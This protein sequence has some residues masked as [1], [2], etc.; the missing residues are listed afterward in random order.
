MAR[1]PSGVERLDLEDPNRESWYF[2]PVHRALIVGDLL[3]GRGGLEADTTDPLQ[4]CP[5]GWYH[6]TGASRAWFAHDRLR[7]VERALELDV[8][9]VLPAHGA[10]VIDTGHDALG[11]LVASA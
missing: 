1:L 9:H 6:E 2:I 8:L 7:I 3:I 4:F 10:A 11:R 5:A